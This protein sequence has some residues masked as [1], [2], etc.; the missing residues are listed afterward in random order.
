[1]AQ[2][3]VFVLWFNILVKEFSF[4]VSRVLSDTV[5]SLCLVQGH[6]L[7]LVEFEPR[8]SPIRVGHS[9]IKLLCT[10]VFLAARLY[11]STGRAIAVTPA[12][13]LLKC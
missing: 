3:F 6:K 8:L 2:L 9:T 4:T 13:S 10:T 1:M 11:E 12:S 7:T 5:W